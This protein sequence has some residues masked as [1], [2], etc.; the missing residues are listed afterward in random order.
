MC[1]LTDTFWLNYRLFKLTTL[2]TLAE[3]KA[4]CF[5]CWQKKKNSLAKTSK[6]RQAGPTSYAVLK[7]K[8]STQ[9]YLNEAK[10]E[11]YLMLLVQFR[12]KLERT[13]K[14]V[15]WGQLRQASGC[16]LKFPV[17]TMTN[18]HACRFTVMKEK[19]VYTAWFFTQIWLTHLP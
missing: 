10:T 5:V 8:S 15:R 2:D 18:T 12:K 16:C 1:G 3:K 11:T 19:V 9:E 17:P 13:C 14:R 7:W 4:W 6:W